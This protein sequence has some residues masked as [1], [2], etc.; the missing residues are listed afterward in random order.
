MSVL[1]LTRNSRQGGH[2][3][4]VCHPHPCIE[5]AHGP[6]RTGTN[7]SRFI[8]NGLRH[9][10]RVLGENAFVE[11][12]WKVIGEYLYDA[13]GGRHQAFYAPRRDTTVLGELIRPHER[14]QVEQSLKYSAAEAEELWKRAGMAEIGQWRHREEYGE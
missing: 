13:E 6:I 9:A 10:N 1:Y 3:P 12:D 14:V 7:E 8:L 5:Y 2:H 4:R 11:N